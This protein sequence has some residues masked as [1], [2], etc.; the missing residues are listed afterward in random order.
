MERD[1]MI[2]PDKIFQPFEIEDNKIIYICVKC[3]GERENKHSLFCKRCN[4]IAEHNRLP[5]WMGS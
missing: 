3:T 2:L 1:T 4:E 5:Y